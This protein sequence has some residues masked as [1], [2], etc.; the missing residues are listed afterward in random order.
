M[1]KEETA[2]SA[3]YFFDYVPYPKFG[4]DDTSRDIVWSKNNSVSYRLRKKVAPLLLEL[5]TKLNP[6]VILIVPSSTPGKKN[7]CN[8]LI[9]PSMKRKVQVLVRTEKIAK[10]EK[11][12]ASAHRRTLELKDY[13][14]T[15]DDRI[16]II[17]D[18]V[19]YGGSLK[20]TEQY[21]TECGGTVIAVIALTATIANKERTA[22]KCQ[23][24]KLKKYPE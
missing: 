15:P 7:L 11:R 24:Y 23:S 18:V 22:Y 21:V 14:I 4:P 20:G 12:N 5:L 13:T 17:D 9:P 16:V 10:E 2:L 1:E 3:Y 8:E 6:T 19:T